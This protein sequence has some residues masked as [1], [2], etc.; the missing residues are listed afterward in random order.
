MGR[1]HAV[2]GIT[3]AREYDLR[4]RVEELEAQLAEADQVVAALA[5]HPKDEYG[6]W[7]PIRKAL[8]RHQARRPK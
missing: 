4:R 1:M 7:S 6:E 3:Y 2:D 5:A 8:E